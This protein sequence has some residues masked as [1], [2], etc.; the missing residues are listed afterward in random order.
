MNMEETCRLD[1]DVLETQSFK[2]TEVFSHG[3]KHPTDFHDTQVLSEIQ[4][5][6]T[7]H[8]YPKCIGT[9]Y[10]PWRTNILKWS[11]S[12]ILIWVSGKKSSAG[13]NNNRTSKCFHENEVVFSTY[14]RIIYK[15]FSTKRYRTKANT[16]LR[17]N[18]WNIYSKEEIFNN[19]TTCRLFA[20]VLYFF[21]GYI[22][23]VGIKQYE[24]KNGI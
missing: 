12:N 20:S 11:F 16:W 7:V 13:Q 10:F 1:A 9:D 19:I 2:Y 17:E 14:R 15:M 4:I 21:V 22:F 6:E 5:E 8:C 3:L 24:I 18:L 23:I